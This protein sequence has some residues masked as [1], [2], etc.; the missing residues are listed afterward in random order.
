MI[1]FEK[2]CKCDTVLIWLGESIYA[3]M[4]PLQTPKGIGP[5][6]EWQLAS[7]CI[8][9]LH[10]KNLAAKRPRKPFS[11]T[12]SN[13]ANK[14]LNKVTP[15]KGTVKDSVKGTKR[16]RLDIDYKQYHNEGRVSSRSPRTS[17]KPLPMASGPSAERLAAQDYI[18]Q[19]KRGLTVGAPVKLDNVKKEL[20]PSNRLTR[21]SHKL[22]KEEPSIHMVHRKEKLMGPERVIHPSGRLCKTHNRGGY[23]DDELPDLPTL[24]SGTPMGLKSPPKASRCSTRASSRV[25][26]TPVTCVASLLSGFFPVT[27]S[28]PRSR[29]GATNVMPSTLAGTKSS[30]KEQSIPPSL[31]LSGYLP[32]PSRAAATPKSHRIPTPYTKPS[33]ENFSSSI[34]QDILTEKETAT[35]YSDKP[36]VEETEIQEVTENA[37]ME[38][39][40]KPD[41]LDLVELNEVAERTSA[42]HALL[43]DPTPTPSRVATTKDSEQNKNLPSTDALE[44]ARVVTTKENEQN[45]D[46]PTTNALE[47]ARAV[48]TQEFPTANIAELDNIS[49]PSRV[50]PTQVMGTDREPGVLEI[51]ETLLQLHDTTTSDNITD[52]EQLLPVDVPKQADV[53]K[54]MAESANV[55]LDSLPDLPHV[56]DAPDNADNDDDEDDDATIIYELPVTP[57]RENTAITS[58][59]RGQVMFRTYGI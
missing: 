44:P 55:P 7:E 27:T 22:V 16:K 35:E 59:R 26:T 50:V 17:V 57:A 58:P 34:I 3:K 12:S 45:K 2:L 14:E 39:S 30:T 9:H 28:R 15:T 52:N 19:E 46:L 49:T 31:V 51:A 33:Q 38:Y 13:I 6:Q 42:L 23:W 43:D 40:I 24:T 41:E 54:E 18:T 4:K 8:L 47:R 53:V 11:T 10:E 1:L 25:V 21:V 48:T 5:L 29:A 20:I 32:V 56:D 36:R 37:N